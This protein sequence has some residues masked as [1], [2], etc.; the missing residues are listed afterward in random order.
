MKKLIIALLTVVMVVSIIF[1]GCVTAPTPEP[2][3]QPPE[4]SEQPPEEPEPPPTALPK[5]GYWVGQTGSSQFEFG[6]TVNPDSTEITY[7]RYHFE[8]LGCGGFQ[9]EV[10]LIVGV[11]AP[12]WGEPIPIHPLPSGAEFTVD[13]D[14]EVYQETDYEKFPIETISIYWHIVIEGKFDETGAHAA[15][16]WEISAEGTT[17]QEGTWEASAP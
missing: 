7:I 6:F 8:E 5:P 16:T 4:T 2:P 14:R 10:M 13:D 11:N 1:A 9:P 15:G 3:E 17:C 12:R